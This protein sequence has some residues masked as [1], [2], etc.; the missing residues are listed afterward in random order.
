MLP[1]TTARKSALIW[2]L[3]EVNL[4][5]LHLDAVCCEYVVYHPTAS[6]TVGLGLLRLVLR[7]LFTIC[8]VSL[9]MR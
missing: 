1:L 4:P 8:G 3:S 5:T 9:M 7:N 6:L 2:F